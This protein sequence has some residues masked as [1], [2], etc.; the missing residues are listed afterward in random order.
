ML[1]AGTRSYNIQ[2]GS[3]SISSEK[4]GQLGDLTKK[5]LQ[6]LRELLDR[7]DKLLKKEKFLQTLP[8]KGVKVKTFAQTLRT[9]IAQ[10]EEIERAAATLEGVTISGHGDKQ[11]SNRHRDKKVA[12]IETNQERK[13]QQEGD[14]SKNE[15]DVCEASVTRND[16]ELR[17]DKSTAMDVSDRLSEVLERVTISTDHRVSVGE[18]AYINSYERVI[19]KANEQTPLKK[20]FKPNS[21]LKI[22]KVEDLPEVYKFRSKQDRL[23]VS[24]S[25]GVSV[26]SERKAESSVDSLK[27]RPKDESAVVL[28]DYKH[29]KSVLISVEE[30]LQ[31]VSQQRKQHGE[32]MM[33]QATER[34]AGRLH[35]RLDDYN[36]EGT[37]MDYRVPASDTD[38]DDEPE[39]GGY[40]DD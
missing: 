21:T 36:P 39:M 29:D 30:S 40:N 12:A 2:M 9:L 19:K 4:Q 20:A 35:I 11:T 34:L 23:K 8:D 22:S 32:L 6:E 27:S 14:N 10:R 28:P 5:T 13:V 37:N 33:R 7:Q 1:P 31:L 18:D 25:S 24:Q 38:S 17:G 26:G 16:T 15:A 3:M